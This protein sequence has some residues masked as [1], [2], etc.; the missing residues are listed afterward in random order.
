M[1]FEQLTRNAGGNNAQIQALQ[2]D[3][4]FMPETVNVEARTVDVTF[5]T[6]ASVLR[7]TWSRGTYNETLSLD[8]AH[9]RMDRLN[10]RAPF[11]DNHN[12]WGKVTECVFG[13]VERAWIE[14]GVG[15]ATIRFSKR[16]NADAVFQDVVDGILPNI[17]VGYRVY[18]YEITERE[19]AP[20]DYRAIDWEP[21][22]IST[23]PVPADYGAQVRNADQPAAQTN[24]VNLIHT[25]TTA[26]EEETRTEQGVTETPTTPVVETRTVADNPTPVQPAT[27]PQPA[28]PAQRSATDIAAGERA[29]I[30]RIQSAVRMAGLG[31]DVATR[32]IDE[33]TSLEAAHEE[34][35]RQW[36]AAQPAP[37]DSRTP[38]A[39]LTGQSEDDTRR[40]A[41]TLA[42]AHRASGSTEELRE[43]A[44]QYRNLNLLGMARASLEARGINVRY[45][46]DHEVARHA[47]NLHLRTAA[48]G[49]HTSS[50]FPIIL[51]NTVNRTL[52]AAYDLQQRTFQAFCRRANAKDFRE[53]TRAQISGMVGKFEEIPEGGEYKSGTF[54]EGAESY[55]L[56][57]YGKKIAITWETIVNDDLDAFSR[58][59]AAIAAEA[60]Q[61]QSD[62]VYGII[63]GNPNMSDGNALFSTEHT[64]LAASGGAI[65]ITS[66][67]AARAAFRKQ[68]SLNDRYLNLMPQF[69]IVGPDRETEAEQILS[70]LVSPNQASQ[71]NVF[72]NKLSLVIDPRVGSAWYLAAAPTNID[73][74]EYAFL[75]G[76][77]ELYTETRED[78]D[79]D[80][81]Q[82]KA[83]MTFAA[84][85]IDWR[86]LYKNAGA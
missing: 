75:D 70:S 7:R 42:L 49:H 25:N 37:S 56:K 38:T 27:A 20:D 2:L 80:G 52:R 51:G 62:I 17:S 9:V 13:V 82:V 76:D 53:I 48:A 61:L 40:E 39:T 30:R 73:T 71:V 23:V 54:T 67:S 34:I 83:R 35:T 12:I 16:D 24:E 55:K 84:K 19:G 6:E 77:G 78:F 86:G 46:S 85:A 58:I 60:A 63:N 64:N 57:K 11:C 8:P 1:E 47:M 4:R 14:G 31:D 41:M 10:A 44:R 29:R 18:T 74:I 43:D 32:L 68:K 66:L 28:Q 45:M 79:I 26:M 3:A 15:R 22:E 33:G 72:A 59:P 36:E 69:L 81:M 65:S 21:F 5:A 50:D